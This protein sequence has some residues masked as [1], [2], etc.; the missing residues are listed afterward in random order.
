MSV[1]PVYMN[2]M[3]Q[4]TQDVGNLK[5]QEDNKPIV[6]QYNIETRQKKQEDQL[7]HQVQQSQ[8]KENEGFRYDAKEK[9]SNSYEGNRKKKKEQKEEQKSDGVVLLKGHG[10]SFD[11]KI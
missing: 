10:G 9:G 5:Q 2:G 8:K 6:Q 11:V 3:I 1:G 4:R 7:I